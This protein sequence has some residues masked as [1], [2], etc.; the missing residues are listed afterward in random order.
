MR[1]KIIALM[2]IMAAQAHAQTLLSYTNV[3]ADVSGGPAFSSSAVAGSFRFTYVVEDTP[4]VPLNLDDGTTFRLEAWAADG[5][6]AHNVASTNLVSTDL[7]SGQVRFVVPSIGVGEYRIRGVAQP[8]G[9]DTTLV[10]QITHH[11]LTVTSA[12]SAGATYPVSLSLVPL[13]PSNGLIGTI[14]QPWGEINAQTARVEKLIAAD[15]DVSGAITAIDTGRVSKLG[16]TMTG[17]LTNA[18]GYYGWAGALTGLNWSAISNAP[19]IPGLADVVTNRG[20]TVNGEPITNGAAITVAQANVGTLQLYTN[21]QGQ[22]GYTNTAGHFSALPGWAL[23]GAGVKTY[24]SDY[25]ADTIVSNRNIGTI[26][27]FFTNGTLVGLLP[28]ESAGLR[29][30]DYRSITSGAWVRAGVEWVQRPQRGKASTAGT[31]RSGIA[32]LGYAGN[33][34]YLFGS[35]NAGA[36]EPVFKEKYYDSNF[37]VAGDIYGNAPY[38]VTIAVIYLS[39]FP[40]AVWD[41]VDSDGT[42]IV[43]GFSMSA[44]GFS[45]TLLQLTTNQAFAGPIQGFAIGV[46]S[47][48]AASYRAT[49]V[50]FQVRRLIIQEGALWIDPSYR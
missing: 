50:P 43:R 44:D 23:P 13:L 48:V 18:H 20:A 36:V 19:T 16:D 28:N 10:W 14:A 35:Q 11:M 30:I 22:I 27:Y 31:I 25:S 24:I 29:M 42:G 7:S 46:S 3:R 41:L 38:D 34:N 15:L 40:N 8:A 33:T 6:R 26:S 21:A 1:T 4:G 2:V 47:D 9:G 12:P 45:P 39:E 5:V 32:W 37:G 17:P 49:N